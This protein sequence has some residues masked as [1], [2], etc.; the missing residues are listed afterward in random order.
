MRSTDTSDAEK[1]LSF[2]EY[3]HL[4]TF[5]FFIRFYAPYTVVGYHWAPQICGCP[6]GIYIHVGGVSTHDFV[7]TG[8]W[9]Q[10][11]ADAAVGLCRQCR[12]GLQNQG[13]YIIYYVISL[14]SSQ[15]TKVSRRPCN[16]QDTFSGRLNTKQSA[17][18]SDWSRCKWVRFHKIKIVFKT[19]VWQPPDQKVPPEGPSTVLYIFCG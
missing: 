13:Y 1:H 10:E 17:C 18:I 12:L 7:P 9:A 2:Y 3:Y 11:P 6:N 5:T 14:L 8:G 4:D 15:I 19:F 16:M